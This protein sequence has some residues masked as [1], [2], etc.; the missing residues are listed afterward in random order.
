M[1]K[2][3]LVS[4]I[5]FCLFCVIVPKAFSETIF[6]YQGKESAT[7]TRKEYNIALLRL[8]LEKTI[9]KYGPFKLVPSPKMN[10]ARSLKTVKA[11]GLRNFF[12]KF[13][14]TDKRI[15]EM[16]YVPFPVDRGIV[17]YRVFFV[18]PTAID[19]LERVKTLDQLKE[20]TIGQGMG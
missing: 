2:V 15:A 8:A 5:F 13:S 20:F 17:G 4:S 9:A 10:A 16:G 7:D 12:V 11:G 3:L 6:T 14:V 18:S 1:K 19:R